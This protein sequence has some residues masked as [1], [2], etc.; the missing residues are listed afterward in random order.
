MGRSKAATAAAAAT[1]V[2]AVVAAAAA[3][4]APSV[5]QSAAM[6][7]VQR[8]S[9]LRLV[10]TMLLCTAA[11]RHWRLMRRRLLRRLAQLTWRLTVCRQSAGQLQLEGVEVRHRRRRQ[12]ADLLVAGQHRGQ[13]NAQRSAAAAAQQRCLSSDTKLRES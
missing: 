12:R 8:L 7:A 11:N 13:R 1:A 2:A 3:A 10:L 9:L 6:L 5:C 4:A